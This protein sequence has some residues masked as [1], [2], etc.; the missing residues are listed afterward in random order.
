MPRNLNKIITEIINFEETHLKNNSIIIPDLHLSYYISVTDNSNLTS[1][2]ENKNKFN[3]LNYLLEKEDYETIA[4]IFRFASPNI[5]NFIF[6][7]LISNNKISYVTPYINNNYN[8][9]QIEIIKMTLDKHLILKSLLETIKSNENNINAE[10]AK[11]IYSL[12]VEK[13]LTLEDMNMPIFENRS[14]NDDLILIN[15]SNLISYIEFLSSSE[16]PSIIATKKILH[17]I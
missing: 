13:Y 3:L 7:Q 8:E 16:F 10:T 6:Y 17:M 2:L 5:Q 1:T 9:E 14:F 4:R 15:K 11:T 12:I